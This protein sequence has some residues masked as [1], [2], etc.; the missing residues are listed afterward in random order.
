M[1]DTLT[2]PTFIHKFT[3]VSQPI[4]LPPKIM[5]LLEKDGTNGYSG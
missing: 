3:D 1:H 4:G 2:W 5:T